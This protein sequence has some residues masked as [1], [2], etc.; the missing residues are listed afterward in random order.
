[1]KLMQWMA[2]L[3]FPPKCTLCG[4]LL[5]KEETD[6]CHS[7]RRDTP[8]HAKSK[9]NI[10]FI[11][12]WTALWYYEG[13]V[14]ESILRY[15]FRNARSY[16]DVYGRLLAM[17]LLREDMEFDLLTWVPIS[18]KRLRKR[19]Y[20]QVELLAYAVGR[21]LDIQPVRLLKKVRNNPPQSEL[22]TRAERRANIKNAYRAENEDILRGK[23]ILLLDDIITTG[24]SAEE[25][26]RILMTAG[27]KNVICAAIAAADHK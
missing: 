25:C 4:R 7:C 16:A 14:R 2:A 5:S 13:N 27:A 1:M 12:Q 3:L 8:E 24:A 22:K 10:P 21:E 23:R 9:L 26:G 20:D 6:L 18:T 15:K 17:K 19:G 11:A